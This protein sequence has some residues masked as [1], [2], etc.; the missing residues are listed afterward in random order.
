MFKRPIRIK[1]IFKQIDKVGRRFKNDKLV[2]TVT[3]KQDAN[4]TT[5]E[6]L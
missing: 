1:Y 3:N 5:K 4:P 6:L 2:G